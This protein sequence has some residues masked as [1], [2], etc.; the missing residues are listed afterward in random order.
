[1]VMLAEETRWYFISFRDPIKNRNLGCCNV[2]IEID[3]AAPEKSGL[4]KALAKTRELGI[5]PGGEVAAFL[6]MEKE[7]E[8]D[9]DRLYTKAEMDKMNYDK[10]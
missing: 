5:N 8:M 6:L 1:M 3:R 4:V 2:S 7:D 9:A 10:L